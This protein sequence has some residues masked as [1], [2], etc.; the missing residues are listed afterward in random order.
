MSASY[1][2]K[3]N[4]PVSVT[5]PA[6]IAL[7]RYS[8]N[9]SLKSRRV[10]AAH[11][12]G[13]QSSFKGR[14]MEYDESR[15]YQAG[16]DIRN[17]DWRVTAR[18]GHAY[19]KLFREERERPVFICV[20]YR[21]AMF[22][23]TRG[24]YKAVVA[25]EAAALLTWSA[26]QYG[27]RVGGMVFAEHSHH[28]FQPKRG[29][30][31]GLYFINQL[32][33]HPAWKDNNNP[34]Q[35]QHFDEETLAHLVRVVRPGSLIFLLSDF[36]YFNERAR[37]HLLSMSRHNEIVMMFIY[38]PFEHSLPDSGRYRLRQG[39]REIELDAYNRQYRREYRRR[40]NDRRGYLLALAGAGTIRLLECTTQDDP[41]L[42]L[43]KGLYSR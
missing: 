13:Y 2:D 36:R 33:Q 22:F 17:L 39:R 25:T 10:L 31:A 16:D 37:L 43:K 20:D 8:R 4:D 27:D 1:S 18:T 34:Q 21:A 42:I 19:T 5:L 32:V 3:Y 24:R 14:G 30:S 23:A 38:D 35:E 11:S 40:F 26:I 41:Y 9:L 6:L 29:Q 12:G 7:S 15:P 28:E